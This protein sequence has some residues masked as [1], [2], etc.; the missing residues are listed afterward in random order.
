MAVN[1]YSGYPKK[2]IMKKYIM[3]LAAILTVSPLKTAAQE[4]SPG[5]DSALMKMIELGEIVIKASKDNVTYKSIPASVS[6]I[7]SVSLSENEVRSLNDISA[8][9]PNFFMPDYGSKLTSPVYIRGIGSRINSPSVGLYVDDTLI[10]YYNFEKFAFDQSRCSNSYSDYELYLNLRKKIRKSY[11]EPGNSSLIYK[12]SP[13]N[14]IYKFNKN[15]IYKIKFEICDIN[16]NVSYVRFDVLG[17]ITKSEQ[18]FQKVNSEIMKYNQTN[19]FAHQDIRIIIPEN[20]LY[21]DIKFLFSQ[22]SSNYFSDIYRV[23]SINTPLNM[24]II[25]SISAEKIP[26]NLVNK[27]IIAEIDLYGNLGSIGGKYINGF[28]TA[29]TKTFGNYVLTV[30]TIP[31]EVEEVVY[32]KKTMFLKQKQISFIINDNVSKIK[33]ISGFIDQKWVLF[34]Y[35]EKNNI[36]TYKFDNHITYGQNHNVILIVTDKKDNTTIFNTSFFK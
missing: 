4:L 1:T 20:C 6:V 24:P 34:K 36:I 21:T 19:F 16:N 28:I 30:D 26:E 7:S 11:T 3:L 22:Y 29:E 5:V 25:I 2:K 31:P 17:K 32:T 8:M 13:G 15:K 18:N 9:A 33:N 10:H 23:H 27:A 12:D 35:D 14:G